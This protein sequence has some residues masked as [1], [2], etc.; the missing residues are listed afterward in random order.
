MT[1]DAWAIPIYDAE[2]LTPQGREVALR[3]VATMRRF[4]GADFTQRAK[5]AQ[6]AIMSDRFWPINRV[7][8]VYANLFQL[9][10]QIELLGL[11]AAPLRRTMRQNLQSESW[12][13]SLL[14][15]E[16]GT[17]G[18]PALSFQHGSAECGRSVADRGIPV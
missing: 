4:L 6:Y 11:R 9:M 10:A 1:W 12:T 17:L 3:A 15:L 7:A 13:H 8:W 5:A 16:V 14:Q 18:L 2:C